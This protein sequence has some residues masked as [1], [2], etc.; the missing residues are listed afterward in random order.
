[1]HRR[2]WMTMVVLLALAG[3]AHG[4][5]VLTLSAQQLSERLARDFPVDRRLLEV[6]DVRVSEPQVR[7]ETASNR[8]RA[9]FRVQAQDRLGGN[10][11]DLRLAVIAGLRWQASDRTLRLER[12]DLDLPPRAERDQE[13][14]QRIG[15]L[16]ASRL[17]EDHVLWRAPADS[18]LAVQRVTVTPAGVEL[19]LVR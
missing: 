19:A 10:R 14:V 12:V 11:L 18:T 8:L 13:R 9:E 16:L 6:F 5:Q 15:L 1:M 3:C 17:F 2:G 7:P 4:P